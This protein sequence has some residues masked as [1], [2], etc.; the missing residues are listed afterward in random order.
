MKL[1]PDKVYI[2]IKAHAGGLTIREI[3]IDFLKV[4]ERTLHYWIAQGRKN[5]IRVKNIEIRKDE[6]SFAEQLTLELF[7]EMTAGE[8]G[9]TRDEVL[10]RLENR[11]NEIESEQLAETEASERRCDNP[12]LRSSRNFQQPEEELHQFR[13]ARMLPDSLEK[14]DERRNKNR[15]NRRKA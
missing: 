6:L 15:S 13:E 10:E 3:A 14:I 2:A 8:Y 12:T 9:E 11:L 1:T 5:F 7:Q 4:S